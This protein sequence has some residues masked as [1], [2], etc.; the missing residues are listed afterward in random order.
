MKKVNNEIENKILNKKEI[1][2]ITG[3]NGIEKSFFTINLSNLLSNKNKILIIDF[4]ILNNDLEKILGIKNYSQ[5]IKNKIKNNNLLK[6]IKTEKLII[7]IN[8]K[9]DLISGINL[10]FDSKYKISNKKIKNILLKLKEKYDVI[11]IN[12]SSECFFDYTKELI[13][14]SD[15]NIFILENNLLEIKKAKN[16]LDI[17]INKWKVAKENINIV[18]NKYTSNSINNY[19]IKNNFP[20]FKIIENCL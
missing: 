6:E 16:L 10:I 4:D 13:K 5:K 1:I 17:Y 14:N 11:I 7:K 20:N 8:S 12:T 18:F 9:I 3:I 19:E 2:C 15:I